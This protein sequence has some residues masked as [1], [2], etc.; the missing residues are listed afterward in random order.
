MENLFLKAARKKYRF[1]TSKGDLNVEQLFSLNKTQL[2][3]LYLSLENKIQASS[4]LLGKKGNVEIEDKL[5]IV[6]EVF[7]TIV[8]EKEKAEEAAKNR[9]LKQ[10]VLLAID[11][12]ERGELK[13]KSLEELK[14]L[15]KSLS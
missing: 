8:E 3:E 13:G 11:E 5:Q 1:K 14:A 10:E 4:G 15:A 12:K 6:K 7:N 9:A 2:N